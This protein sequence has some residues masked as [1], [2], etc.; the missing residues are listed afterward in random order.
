MHPALVFSYLQTEIYTKNSHDSR[1][2]KFG[3]NYTQPVE[4][5]TAKHSSILAWEILW[6]EEPGGLQSWGPKS[7]T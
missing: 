7:Q 1:A 5:E 6:T 2:V 3:L 4:K